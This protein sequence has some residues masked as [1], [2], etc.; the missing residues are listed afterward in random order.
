MPEGD[1]RSEQRRKVESGLQHGRLVRQR[2]G[3]LVQPDA[4]VGEQPID[5][6]L[7][8]SLGSTVSS[9]CKERRRRG[10]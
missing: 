6:A 5:G 8:Q 3:S 2:G 7:A 1:E 10:L 4:E 9:S